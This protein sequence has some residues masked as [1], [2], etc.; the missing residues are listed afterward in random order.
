M[1]RKSLTL[2][3]LYNVI[4]R[5]LNLLFPLVTTTYISRILL[6]EGVGKVA[7]ALNIV[8]YFVII[9][10]LG[11]PN[12]GIREI[13]KVKS[14]SHEQSKVFSELFLLN[15]I[16]TS[17]C[18]LVYYTMIL[19][20]GYFH[21]NINLYLASGLLLFFNYIN[22][23]WFFQGNEEYGYIAIRNT[24]VKFLSVI[25]L[26]VF[27]KDPNDYLN[28]IVIYC[29]ALGGNYILNI[30]RISKKTK[31]SFKDIDLK[32]HFK[33]VIILLA[34]TISIEL[35]TL[36]DV[37]M[38]GVFCD[39]SVV[40]YYNNASK[41]ARMINSLIASIGAVLLPRLSLFYSHHQISDFT[42]TLKNVREVLFYLSIPATLGVFL[43]SDDIIEVL[44]GRRFSPASTTL[45]IMSVLIILVVFNNLYGTQVLIT[46]GQEKR[47]MYSVLAGAFVNICLNCVMIKYFQ[48]NGAAIASVISELTVLVCT[49]I[50]ASK[51]V[52]LRY[53]RKFVVSSLMSGLLMSISVILIRT[54]IA[55]VLAELSISVIA[56]IAVYFTV[57]VIFK[58]SVTVSVINKMRKKA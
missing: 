53:N 5:V 54:M 7:V 18:L 52:D 1:M 3:A 17:V 23:D 26:V 51:F 12:Y 45:A 10:G 43:L 58:N 39:D 32:K 34:S 9:A 19:N 31:L 41:F 16:S 49:R 38:L 14:D 47:L 22:I 40:G 11:I 46:I 42:Q 36:V 13:A 24:V 56:G 8:Q 28:Y 29:L 4:Y 50:F 44:F 15:F 35:Y 37:T 2:N 27:V 6:P 57:T 21:E 48:H 33:P 30:F 55:P 25:M 20:S